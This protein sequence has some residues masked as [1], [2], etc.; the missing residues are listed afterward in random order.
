M[1]IVYIKT[2]EIEPYGNNSKKHTRSQIEK[3][4]KSIKQFG[5]NSPIAVHG[6]NNT[7]VYRHGKFEALK[8]THSQKL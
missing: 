3:I 8:L 4:K 7:I 5:L 2:S 6:E 1:E